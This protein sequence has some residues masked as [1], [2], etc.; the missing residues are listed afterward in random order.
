MHICALMGALNCQLAISFVGG[1][2]MAVSADN[3]T[4]FYFIRLHF[5]HNRA[6]YGMVSSITAE[7]GGGVQESGAWCNG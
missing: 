5:F 3:L 2:Q 4:F 6:Q 1:A 7:F